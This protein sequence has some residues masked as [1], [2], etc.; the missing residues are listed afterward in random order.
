MEEMRIQ[1]LLS[2]RGYCSRR[3]AEQLIEEKRVKVNGVLVD[4]LGFTCLED[5]QIEI[6]GKKIDNKIKTE[7][8]YLAL[9]K[10]INV[11]STLLD[12][13]K[14]KTVKEYIPEKYNR[15]YP[16][17]RLDYNSTGLMILTDDGNFADLI[18]HP[19]S[20]PEK[21]Y[22]VRVKGIIKDED[23]EK[24][25][26]GV[27]IIMDG[28]YSAPARATILKILDDSSILSIILHEGKKREIRHLMDSLN[29]PVIDL[30]R[31]RIG[32]VLL[33]DLKEGESKEIDKI[34]IN[35]LIN[36]CKIRKGQL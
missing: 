12:P 9:N 8:T 3:K 25:K 28:Y 5:A 26:S 10:P 15:L 11:V 1:K 23:I 6:D 22:I 36:E 7:F 4:R 33:D 14:R 29:H 21:E 18:T 16:V 27:Y 32:N 35:N 2:K 13:Q 24:I 20:A 19:S 31:I 34:V 17:G 30:C